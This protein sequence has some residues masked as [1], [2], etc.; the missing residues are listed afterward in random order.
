MADAPT[1][2]QLLQQLQGG[3][4][5]AASSGS[6]VSRICGLL[7]LLRQQYLEKGSKGRTP[8]AHRLLTS[9]LG[10]MRQAPEAEVR[11]RHIAT[12]HVSPIARTN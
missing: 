12:L 3:A 6:D 1:G 2:D 9:V 10:A 11:R 8:D 4:S 5:D 7:T